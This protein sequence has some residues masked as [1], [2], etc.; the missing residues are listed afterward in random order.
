[1]STIDP[2][3]ALAALRSTLDGH[4]NETARQLLAE[5]P[6]KQAENRA[7]YANIGAKTHFWKRAHPARWTRATWI[8]VAL[9][10]LVIGLLP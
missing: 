5:L 6:N 3:A 9:A 8:I 2:T 10:S 4:P 7:Q 1:M